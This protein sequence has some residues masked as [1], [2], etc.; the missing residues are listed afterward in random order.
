M[1][2]MVGAVLEGGFLR[3]DLSFFRAIALGDSGPPLAPPEFTLTA[4][5]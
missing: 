3:G 5:F 2:E 1:W 4:T